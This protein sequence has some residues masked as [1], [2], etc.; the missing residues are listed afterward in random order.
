[1][2]DPTHIGELQSWG[3]NKKKYSA[4]K[5]RFSAGA[6]QWKDTS[7]EGMVVCCLYFRSPPA[8][9]WYLLLQTHR[10]TARLR[11]AHQRSFQHHTHKWG[12]L[13]RRRTE[14]KRAE[15]QPLGDKSALH[16]SSYN[17][18]KTSGLE[19]DIMFALFYTCW[20][21]IRTLVDL[22]HKYHYRVTVCVQVIFWWLL[23]WST[24]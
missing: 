1:M 20:A 4:A 19:D 3:E 15:W 17:G 2:L 5:D 12:M 8:G 23:I 21:L 18:N 9:S 16:T 14:T 7:S 13:M 24:P 11:S 6:S 22:Y 10:D